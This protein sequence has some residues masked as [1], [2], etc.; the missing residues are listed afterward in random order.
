MRAPW[1]KSGLHAGNMTFNTRKCAYT[2]TYNFTYVCFYTSL[3]KNILPITGKT[4]LQMQFTKKGYGVV[5]LD[6]FYKSNQ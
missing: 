4:Y 6:H 2:Y 5:I 3:N 1:V